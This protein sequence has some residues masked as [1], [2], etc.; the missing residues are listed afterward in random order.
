M[1]ATLWAWEQVAPPM[2]E[3]KD[4]CAHTYGMLHP[5]KRR[6][7]FSKWIDISKL[8]YLLLV[9]GGTHN[10]NLQ[11]VQTVLNAA[12][13][14]VLNVGQKTR[15]WTLMERCKWLYIQELDTLH[16]LVFLW[17]VLHHKRPRN[18]CG[19]FELT[20]DD[21]VRTL[22]ACL[23]IADSSYRWQVASMW[24]NLPLEIRQIDALPRFKS[25]LRSWI[26][27]RILPEF[28]R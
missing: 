28:S 20:E 21:L 17:K 8:L 13:W 7:L 22:V 27:E 12:A 10:S 25:R 19:K 15:V 3:E 16:S 14:V 6:T 5:W 24:N 11:K 2:F 18:L 9:W 4:W 26:I 1:E 23:Q